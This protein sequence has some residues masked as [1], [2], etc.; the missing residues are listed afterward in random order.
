MSAPHIFIH[1]V[2]GHGT[3]QQIIACVLFALTGPILALDYWQNGGSITFVGAVS[4]PILLI[5]AC[6]GGAVSFALFVGRRWWLATIPGML[7]GAGA[8]GLHLWW[9]SW[10]EK[11]EMD[12]HESVGVAFS[13]TL[14]GI[15]L[16]WALFKLFG[17]KEGQM[18][19]PMTSESNSA[20]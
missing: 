8:F 20:P 5:V 14:P 4:L 13:G 7:S 10:M 6:S 19:A 12:T 16:C 17:R 9:T 15:F 11:Q 18:T 3:R 2:G 1:P